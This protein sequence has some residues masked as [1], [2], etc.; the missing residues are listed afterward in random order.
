MLDLEDIALRLE[1]VEKTYRLY[2]SPLDQMLDAL[3][4]D[5]IFRLRRPRYT[6][7][8]ALKG[9]DLTL[10]RG[11]R[12]GIIG[13]NGAGK[14][15]LLKIITGNFAPSA[16]RVLVNGQIQS[17]MDSGLGFHPEMSGLEN[18]RS[19]LVYNGLSVRQMRD[20]EEDIISFCE[21]G[22]FIDQPLKTYSLGMIARLG[23]A[24]ATAIHPDILIIDEVMG[25]GDA[26]FMLK[27]VE[28][29]KRL[30]ADGVTLILVS[31]S[32]SQIVQFCERAIWM[33]QGGIRED[34]PSLE[35]VKSYERHIRLLEEER[36]KKSNAEMLSRAQ[37]KVLA[38]AVK[39]EEAAEPS[40]STGVAI[41]E[42]VETIAPT[43]AVEAETSAPDAQEDVAEDEVRSLSRWRG[44]GAFL[45]DDVRFLNEEG[46]ARYTFRSGERMQVEIRFTSQEEGIREIFYHLC[47]YT[48]DG[49]CVTMH[50]S[51]ADQINAEKGRSYSA[52]LDFGQNTFGHGPLVVTAGLYQEIDMLRVDESKYYDLMDRSYEIRMISPFERDPSLVHMQAKWSGARPEPLRDISERQLELP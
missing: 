24:T 35:V 2:E 48:L 10:K 1:G 38:E 8:D 52:K 41:V 14:S 45:I 9:V 4:M 49:R 17:L 27:S 3:N 34:G 16:G 22:D 15:T 21:L 6:R 39:P 25:A 51:D 30:T 23:F 26:Y 19:S 11:E 12:L 43:A 47:F 36:L 31:H 7:F 20:A 32:T 33:D 5:W 18:L 29:M 44:T 50:L 40:P 42:P 37:Q 28:R 46:E 13:R